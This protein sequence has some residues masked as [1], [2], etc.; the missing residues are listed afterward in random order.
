MGIVGPGRTRTTSGMLGVPAL[1]TRLWLIRRRIRRQDALAREL[2]T[3]MRSV[4]PQ[5]RGHISW[6]LYDYRVWERTAAMCGQD[7]ISQLAQ[8]L[9]MDTRLCAPRDIF[10]QGLSTIEAYE[11]TWKIILDFSV[12]LPHDKFREIRKIE[13]SVNRLTRQAFDR[14]SYYFRGMSPAELIRLASQKS[15]PS[16]KYSFVSLSAD[17]Q[18][19]KT[20]AIRNRSVLS[21]AH[22]VAIMN[23]SYMRR[24]QI[25]PAIYSLASDVLRFGPSVEGVHRT[26]RL[27]YA[28]ELQAH[29]PT[30][31][32]SRASAAIVAA[33][34]IGNVS[35]SDL[36]GL[37]K[38]NIMALPDA[39]FT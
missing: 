38:A 34:L 36:D 11:K 24:L 14:A 1:R 18:I 7:R 23:A 2:G 13:D 29:M 5:I 15:V 20:R 21:S 30:I 8:N 3:F 25:Q 39:S 26:F 17:F 31:W 12:G 33:A 28:H 22:I 10:L 9:G 19:A 6:L 16:K 35:E 32:P 4:M 37:A 27:G